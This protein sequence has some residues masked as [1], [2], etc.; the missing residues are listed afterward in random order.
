MFMMARNYQPNGQARWVN[1]GFPVGATLVNQSPHGGRFRVLVNDA[2]QIVD[3]SGNPPIVPPNGW[4]AFTWHN[5]RM[6]RVW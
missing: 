2:G 6:P 1:T 4:F 5:P 3:G